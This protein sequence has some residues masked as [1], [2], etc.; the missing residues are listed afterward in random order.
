MAV[1]SL[2]DIAERA[3]TYPTRASRFGSA[4]TKLAE[5]VKDYVDTAVAGAGGGADDTAYGVSWDGDTE[6]AASK[7]ALYD[8]L[9]SM[10]TAIAGA[11]GVGGGA[12]DEAIKITSPAFNVDMLPGKLYVVDTAAPS[13]LRVPLTANASPGD[14][15]RI[16]VI[17]NNA[18]SL[19]QEIGD[20]NFR[21]LDSATGSQGQV[22]NYSVTT[23]R[24]V[25]MTYGV[26]NDI[27][28][29]IVQVN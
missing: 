29:W 10:D 17:G 26:T 19:N 4:T 11:G 2:A 9:D 15:I 3:K 12:F 25:I 27:A 14:T 24:S 28:R 1:I 6:V 22:T 20:V 21:Y 16:W 7:N 8:K 18:L 5:S 23:G 13:S